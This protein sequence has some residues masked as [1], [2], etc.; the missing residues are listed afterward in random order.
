MRIVDHSTPWKI[1]W[2]NFGE[3]M[4][5]NSRSR[6]VDADGDH[7]IT[8]GDGSTSQVALA[9][10]TAALI[11]DAVNER[12]VKAYIETDICPG[13]YPGETQKTHRYTWDTAD[14]IPRCVL[15]SAQLKEK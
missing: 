2:T 11:V 13:R 3:S 14:G 5:Y 9:E 4:G 15:C 10:R 1:E 12:A 8:I 7:V 6:I